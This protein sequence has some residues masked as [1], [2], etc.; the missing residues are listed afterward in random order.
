VVEAGIMKPRA[1]ESPGCL[2]VPERPVPERPR[3]GLG[4]DSVVAS[5]GRVLGF[6]E[7]FGPK[8]WHKGRELGRNSAV[9]C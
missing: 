1:V 6:V 8:T 2:I 7:F 9:S 5:G 3:L 4:A